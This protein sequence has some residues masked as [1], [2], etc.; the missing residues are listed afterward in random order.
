M[1]KNPTKA[2]LVA[3]FLLTTPAWPG[4][5]EKVNADNLLLAQGCRGC[6]I[7]AE[8]GGT[9]GPSLDEVGR[10]LT[11]QQIRQKLVDPELG[12]PTSRMPDFKHLNEQELDLLADFL[13]QLR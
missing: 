5:A 4:H 7:V 13:L 10:R 6:H 1:L 11:R 2:L 9:L 8:I 12:N 3:L